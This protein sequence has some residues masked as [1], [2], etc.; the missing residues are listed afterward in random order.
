V[1]DQVNV[2]DYSLEI[3]GDEVVVRDES[4]AIVETVDLDELE[5][6]LT[7][8]DGQKVDLASVLADSDVGAFQTAAGPANDNLGFINGGPA[9]FAP[10]QETQDEFG[11]LNSAGTLSGTSLGFDALNTDDKRSYDPNEQE[12]PVL[13]TWSSHD[14]WQIAENQ[15]GGSLGRIVNGNPADFKFELSDDRFEIVD[16]ILQARD[17]VSFDYETESGI[18]IEITATSRTGDVQTLSVHIDVT[19]VNEAQTDLSIDGT[20][21]NEN[22]AGAVI[23]TLTVADP[24]G[25]DVQS[26]AVSDDRFEVVDGQ[27]KLKDGL[28]LDHESEPAIDVTVTAT[29]SVGNQITKTF[30]IN[31]GDVNEAP[32]D[33]DLTGNS[34]VENVAGAVIGALTAIDP[35]AG[36]TLSFEVSDAR[37]EVVNGQLKLKDGASIDFETE[38]GLDV[39]VTATDSAGNSIQETFSLSVCNVNEA[40]TALM[41]DQDRVPENA[42]GA[43]VGTLAVADQDSGDTQIFGVSDDRFEVV[44]GQLKLK[45]GVSLDRE[46]EPA[47]HLQVTA[48]DSAGHQIQ[49]TFTI[50][51]ADVNE[52][53]SA[54]ALGGSAVVENVAGAVIGALTVT[55]PDA[56]DSQN[57]Q[58]SDDRFEVVDGQLK[59][60]DGVSLDHE[61]E[62]M[63]NVEVTATDAAGNQIAET[64]TIIVGDV[65][66]AQASLS[67]TKGSVAENAKGAVIGTVLVADPDA[68]DKQ[69]YVVSDSR[70]QIVNGQLKLKS[71]VSINHESEPEVDVTVTATDKSGH[72]IA[73]TFM[74]DVLDVNEKQTAMTLTGTKVTENDKGAVI[75][76]LDVSDPDAGDVQSYKV[77]D[78]RFEVVDG[79]LKLKD[80][81]SLN[82]ESAANVNVK[83]TA[84]DT[85]NHQIA[86][87]FTINVQNVNEAQT[88]MTL[89]GSRVSENAAGAVVGTLKVTDPDKGDGQSYSVSDNRFEVV[90]GQLKLKDG[91][92]LNYEEAKSIKVGV[93]ATD[94]ADHQITKTFTINVGN[95]NEAQTAMTLSANSAKENAAGAVIGTL[96]VTDPDAGDKQ[97]FTVSDPRFEVVNNKLKLRPGVS[98]DYEQESS[99]SV[100]VTATD[101]GG[102]QITS[103][104]IID[105]GDVN[106]AQAALGLDNMQVSE[107]APGA[108]IGN[109]SVTDPDA[110]D[111]QSFKVSDNRFEVVNG[112]L[113]LKDGVSFDHETTGSVAVTVTA[114]DSAKHTIS[115]T[116]TIAIGDVNEAQT[117]ISLDG[118]QMAENATGAVIGALSVTDPDAGDLQSFQVS[119]SRFEVIDGQLKLKDGASLDHESEPSVDVT[120]TATDQGGNQIQQTFTVAVGDVNE[121]PTVTGTNGTL[122]NH[123][124]D[125]SESYDP[126]ASA[127]TGDYLHGTKGASLSSAAVTSGISAEDLT[128]FAPTEVTVTFQKEGA[129]YHNMV[130]AYRLDDSGNIIPG[131]VGFIWL[132]ASANADNKLGAPLIKD[133]LGFSQAGTV[134]LGTIPEGTH[135]G[136]FTIANGAADTG[137]KALLTSAAAGATSQTAA[138]DAIASQLSITI[139]ANGNGRVQIGDSQLNGDTYFTHNKALNTDF[140]GSNDIGHVVAGVSGNMPGQLLIG[141]ED[142]KGGGD[143]DYEDVVFS[144]AMGT[145]NVNKL[146]HAAVQPNVDFSDV[147]G[148]TLTQAVIQTS[149]FLAG[150]A[151][152]VPPSEHF[153]VTINQAGADYAIIIVGKTGTETLDQYEDFA[154]S[155]YFS[156]SSQTEGARH[157]GYTVTDS[158]G[159][160]SKVSTADI[161]V[162]NSYEVSSSQLGDSQT[163]GSGGDLLHINAS[164]V[165]QT[166]MGDGY[167]TVHL[168]RQNMS[169]GHD[170]AVKLS[171]VEA[172]DSTGYGANNVSLSIDDVLNMT[173][174][175]NRLTIIGDKGDSVTLT[176]NGD[177]QWTVIESNA[178][179]TAYAYSDPSMQAVVEISNQLNAQVS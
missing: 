32:I 42:S 143:R 120:V 59:L 90:N 141:F 136:F 85:G 64:F 74:I 142:L 144:V 99:I 38:P 4:G 102:N 89:S 82:F 17:G 77:S 94:S 107:N 91:V 78:K 117:A 51:V 65:N 103:T 80:G 5:G 123:I 33:I 139:D 3:S 18:E 62:A 106:E 70:F 149:G 29:D 155:I 58:V 157:I 132:D 26:L 133:F 112:R 95:V 44:D 124:V 96:K 118:S 172:I 34:L 164:G 36:D 146:T 46:S 173:D 6:E 69:S 170:E 111:A 126:Q 156:T 175:D 84:I 55:D 130:G 93:T 57:F 108:V 27:L 61:A 98:L 28:S 83:V 39:V 47:I 109:L 87:T 100:D 177:A 20:A 158:G 165:G 140:T 166:D 171:N 54:L 135:L 150:D 162:T 21:A 22:V 16:G 160:T 45:D 159:L 60:K 129:G 116:F 176:G 37:F 2:G 75:G 154:N 52:G 48:I 179:F 14:P 92:S 134:S 122:H 163:L 86:K 148:S 97:S 1:S 169:F 88:A 41:L 7:L 167:D 56:A 145:Y 125:T 24:D 23:G 43:V 131:S 9:N 11:G 73:Q 63:V 174:G 15:S 114:T 113:K 137:N 168:A 49:Q 12:A 152:N 128:L 81:V 30:T 25:G 153:D 67:L 31:V 8:P 66:E 151:L 76:T 110:G 105:V 72:K 68:G 138:M 79:Q 115:H 178:E 161:G 71:G 147:D 127:S 104:F 40:Q 13:V 10:F 119:D 19:D 35:D 53:Q 121:A 50:N 101:K